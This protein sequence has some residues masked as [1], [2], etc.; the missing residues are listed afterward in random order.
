VFLFDTTNP[1]RIAEQLRT[2]TDETGEVARRA[3]HYTELARQGRQFVGTAELTGGPHVQRLRTDCYYRFRKL[4]QQIV[5]KA[6]FHVSADDAF[7][8]VMRGHSTS[9]LWP[10]R[11]R[12]VFGAK[13]SGSAATRQSAAASDVL[14]SKLVRIP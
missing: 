11:L 2:V 4:V 6:G 13:N 5:E 9:A 8:G 1:Q 3:A 7:Q 12:R 10:A 14:H